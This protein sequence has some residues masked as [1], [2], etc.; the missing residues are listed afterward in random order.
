[1]PHSIAPPSLPT[2]EKSGI[3][4]HN[5]SSPKHPQSNGLAE[6]TVQTA[7]AMLVKALHDGKDPY[8]AILEQRNTPVDNFKLPAQLSMGRRLRSILPCT[9][10]QLLPETPNHDDVHARLRRKQ[11]AQKVL[12]DR[13]AKEL[14]PLVPGNTVRIKQ[15]PRGWKP[16]IVTKLADAPCS[17]IVQ[18]QDGG[19]V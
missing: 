7:K 18:T 15:D 5:T 16:A 1:M 2:L 14:E 12:Y 8:L 6:W 9:T 11:T 19:R 4:K 10:R 13:T 3:S 17:Y